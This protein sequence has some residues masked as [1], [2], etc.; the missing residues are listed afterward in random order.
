M[1]FAGRN[2]PRKDNILSVWSPVPFNLK[3]PLV[4][5]HRGL[6]EIALENTR[7]SFELAIQAGSD[8]VETDVH[9]TSD[10]HVV[11]IHDDDLLRIAG[12]DERIGDLTLTEARALFPALLDYA[13]FMSMTKSMPVIVDTKGATAEAFDAIAR[14]TE[15]A[16][17]LKRVLFT[18]YT[19][20][21]ARTIRRRTPD[22]AITIHAPEG[23]HA[24]HIAEEVKA[25]CIRLLPNEHVAERIADI[26]RRGF[27]TIA[28]AAPLSS[29]RTSTTPEALR[30]IAD[31][32]IRAVIT[33]R[34]DWALKTFREDD[35][36]R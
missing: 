36:A 12:S 20:E 28:V 19:Y 27:A 15:R 16:E 29:T 2:N 18:A 17:G 13:A 6:P 24:L 26:H 35:A 5:G 4:I 11:C 25:S 10:G 21:L 30:A 9:L 3:R 32:G 34:A 14:A 23:L 33:D 31:L 22:A 1:L 7:R 8:S